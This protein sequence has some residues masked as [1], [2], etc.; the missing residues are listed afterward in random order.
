MYLIILLN[1]NTFPGVLLPGVLQ[2]RLLTLLSIFIHILN[3]SYKKVCRY[4]LVTDL[5]L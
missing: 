2:F 3:L 1:L 4:F 5:G